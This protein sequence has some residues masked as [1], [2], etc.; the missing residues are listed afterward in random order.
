M[1]E[2]LSQCWSSPPSFTCT[3]MLCGSSSL[4][5]SG[6]LTAEME[7]AAHMSIS[8]ERPGWQTLRWSCES[9]SVVGHHPLLLSSPP[10]S[11][12]QC[13]E[14]PRHTALW[15]IVPPGSWPCPYHTILTGF[16]HSWQL[17][18]SCVHS[19]AVSSNSI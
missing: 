15:L 16:S 19:S 14:A 13:H 1:K 10:Q 18:V 8:A 17:Q 11:L 4:P 3:R 5:D 12:L 2:A 9:N 6:S 7:G